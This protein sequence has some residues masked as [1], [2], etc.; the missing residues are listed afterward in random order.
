MAIADATFAGRREAIWGAGSTTVASDSTH[1][2]AFDQNLFTQWHSRYGGRGALIYWHVERTHHVVPGPVGA[3]RPHSPDSQE[4]RSGRSRSCLREEMPS[5]RKMLRRW[6]STVRGL[7]N[8]RAA[9]SLD[10]APV[11]TSR[12]MCNSCMVS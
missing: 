5:L 2:A 7:M 9:K 1:M 6:V 3:G 8:S 12:A 11:A 10:V 4:P